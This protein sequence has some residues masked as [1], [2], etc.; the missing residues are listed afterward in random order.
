ML[1]CRRGENIARGHSFEWREAC[2]GASPK[3][4]SLRFLSFPWGPAAC[5]NRLRA[6]WRCNRQRRIPPVAAFRGAAPSSVRLFDEFDFLCLESVLLPLTRSICKPT[7][8]E[9]RLS[10]GERGEIQSSASSPSSSS[11][12]SS[13]APAPPEFPRLELRPWEACLRR[14]LL[15]S[16]T[17]AVCSP[18]RGRVCACVRE[19]RCGG[20]RC[21]R[22]PRRKSGGV[23]GD[24]SHG[25]TAEG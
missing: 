9:N 18:C 16:S 25:G 2:S 12:S 11:S 6:F 19:R 24:D 13:L 8:N 15:S 17:R 7:V 22:G 23:R 5:G 4:T 1:R 21:D 10:L 3:V 20:Q 14:C